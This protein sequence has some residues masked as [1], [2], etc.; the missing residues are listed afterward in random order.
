MT[1]NQE[2][3]AWSLLI[4]AVMKI[5]ENVAKSHPESKVLFSND[6]VVH[7]AGAMEKIIIKADK[8]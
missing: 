2:R 1:E 4:A 3:A 6:D 5:A 8:D 7:L